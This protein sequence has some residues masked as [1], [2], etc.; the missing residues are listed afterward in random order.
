MKIEEEYRDDRG[1]KHRHW[2]RINLHTDLIKL[3]PVNKSDYLDRGICWRMNVH[4]Q[5]Y[6]LYNIVCIFHHHWH[7]NATAKQTIEDC[8]NVLTSLT[9]IRVKRRVW[10]LKKL[11]PESMVKN[12]KY[13]DEW[14]TMEESPENEKPPIQYQS[15]CE[16]SMITQPAEIYDTETIE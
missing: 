11:L 12:H 1:E 5:I 4:L 10:P 15:R 7:S 13:C 9:Y 6:Y 16:N 2:C 8:F 14:V 3:N